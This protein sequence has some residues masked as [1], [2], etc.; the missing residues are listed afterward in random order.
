MYVRHG[1]A[2]R[3]ATAGTSHQPRHSAHRQPMHF[4]LAARSRYERCRHRRSTKDGRGCAC[5]GAGPTP[6][7]RQACSALTLVR[8]GARRCSAAGSV[9]THRQHG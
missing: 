9:H 7:L 8:F 4:A 3:T 5:C 6:H 1:G 2:P